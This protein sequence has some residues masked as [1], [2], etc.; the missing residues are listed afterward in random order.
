MKCFEC[1]AKCLTNYWRTPAGKIYQITK[2]CPVCN[3]ESY[4]T[5][6]PEKIS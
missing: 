2:Q 3:W 6:V 1:G 4:P 5:K